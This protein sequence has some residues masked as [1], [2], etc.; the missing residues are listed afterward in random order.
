MLLSQSLP[1]GS[2]AVAEAWQ[3]TLNILHQQSFPL[4]LVQCWCRG[5]GPVARSHHLLPS[6]F[7]LLQ[8]GQPGV[9]HAP[10]CKGPPWPCLQIL[11]QRQWNWHQTMINCA[12]RSV[13]MSICTLCLSFAEAV[14]RRQT[15]NDLRQQIQDLRRQL[16]NERSRA[17]RAEFE[18][19][20][21]MDQNDMLNKRWDDAASQGWP[22][23]RGCVKLAGGVQAEA[24]CSRFKRHC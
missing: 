14:G 23:Q 8:R 12:S 3:Q 22:G 7:T 18:H 13:A 24:G 5:G 16:D 20:D 11:L 17:E 2:D 21:A 10:G 6:L 9:R 1:A 19:E 15:V 4:T